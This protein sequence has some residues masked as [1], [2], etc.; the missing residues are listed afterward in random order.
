MTFFINR[1]TL[2]DADWLNNVDRRVNDARVINPLIPPYNAPSNGTA[3]ALSALQAA[4]DAA[5]DVNKFIIDLQGLTYALSGTLKITKKNV[6]LQNFRFVPVFG[7]NSGTI[8]YTDM[9]SNQSGVTA[10]QLANRGNPLLRVSFR[11]TVHSISDFDGVVIKNFQIDG[12]D[13]APG[14][15]VEGCSQSL[16]M[17]FDIKQCKG[18]GLAAL[19]RNTETIFAFGKIAEAAFGSAKQTNP[20]TTPYTTAGFVGQCADI[21]IESVTANYAQYPFWLDRFAN[22]Q[23]SNCHAYN[24]NGAGLALPNMYVG[25]SCDGIMCTNF[26]N[27]RG[28]IELRSFNHSFTGGRFVGASSETANDVYA[29][30]ISPGASAAVEGL[31]IDNIISGTNVAHGTISVDQTAGN[32]TDVR[33]CKIS[34]IACTLDAGTRNTGFAHNK[35]ITQTIASGDWVNEGSVF[36]YD[37]NI[38]SDLA[39]VN[40]WTTVEPTLRDRRSGTNQT[41]LTFGWRFSPNGGPGT[42]TI[43][44]YSTQAVN[45]T[46]VA[47]INEGIDTSLLT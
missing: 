5:D 9:G 7:Y 23:M 31:I 18:Y 37:W 17:G 16:I 41:P 45:C 4:I 10:G 19:V 36:R 42:K 12:A 34:A 43:A 8:V 2:I 44:F 3:D 33:N 47:K 38:E 15:V 26:Y 13:R 22:I 27:D 11:D 29:K 25:P 32:I 30:I 6:T 46:A 35:T 28:F 24:G 1:Q 39:F 21:I 14:M 20:G 40:T